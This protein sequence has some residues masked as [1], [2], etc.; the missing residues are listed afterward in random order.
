MENLESSGPPAYAALLLDYAMGALDSPAALL[1]TTHLSMSGAGLAAV[2]LWRTAATVA[3][4]RT[5]MEITPE[6]MKTQALE[7]VLAR[8]EDTQKLPAHSPPSQSFDITAIP[9]KGWRGLMPGFASY[10]LP[11]PGERTPLGTRLRLFR[12]APGFVVPTHAH[13]G[14]GEEVTLVL[15]GSFQDERGTY[16]P[17][18]LVVFD[19][20]HIAH[21]PRACA[22]KG[23]VCLTLTRGPFVF[24]GLFARILGV[25]LG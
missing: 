25:F 22:Q 8:L 10:D 17:G 3:L 18:D 6:P 14:G 5:F 2:Q 13:G 12:L 7:S 21:T 24:K 1:V 15:D 4:E 11:I 9:Q 23:C 20:E 19:E 16:N